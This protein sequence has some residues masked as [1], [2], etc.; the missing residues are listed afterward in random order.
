MKFQQPVLR[1]REKE[2]APTLS[3]VLIGGVFRKRGSTYMRTTGIQLNNETVNCVLIYTEDP[4]LTVGYHYRFEPK[5]TVYLA[6][7]EIT[8]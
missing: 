8:A 2:P 5:E 6:T 7:V 3:D 1:L 4:D